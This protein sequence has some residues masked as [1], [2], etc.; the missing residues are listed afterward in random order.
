MLIEGCAKPN[1]LYGSVYSIQPNPTSSDNSLYVKVN[2]SYDY[3][4]NHAMYIKSIE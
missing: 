3:K 4:L 2:L 1:N